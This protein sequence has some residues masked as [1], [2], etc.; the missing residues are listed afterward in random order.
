MLYSACVAFRND[1]EYFLIKDLVDIGPKA[2][3]VIICID[4]SLTVAHGW[5]ISVGK[6]TISDDGRLAGVLRR[7]AQAPRG[8][9][10]TGQREGPG[11]PF[12]GPSL[13]R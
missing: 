7:T 6:I 11:E 12:P 5:G 10:T 2:E 3:Q 4:P 13:N 1:G 9:T 8:Q